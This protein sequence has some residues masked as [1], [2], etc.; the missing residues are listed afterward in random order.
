VELQFIISICEV[1]LH[2]IQVRQEVKFVG[3]ESMAV[4]DTVCLRQGAYCMSM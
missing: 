4:G 1:E 2:M 3:S